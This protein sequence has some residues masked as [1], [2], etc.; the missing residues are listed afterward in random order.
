[1]TSFDMAIRH[2]AEGTTYSWDVTVLLGLGIVLSAT[3]REKMLRGRTSPEEA[4]YV[5]ALYTRKLLGRVG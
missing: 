2:I 4:A 1:M 5:T 3:L